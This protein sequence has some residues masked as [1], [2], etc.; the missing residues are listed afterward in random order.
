MPVGRPFEKGQTASENPE[1][2]AGAPSGRGKADVDSFH[3]FLNYHAPETAFYCKRM[4]PFTVNEAAPRETGV[5][6]L[7][8]RPPPKQR[9]LTRER[10]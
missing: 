9:K 6:A 7:D 10:L 5:A 4:E 3:Y 2:R 1:G 8:R